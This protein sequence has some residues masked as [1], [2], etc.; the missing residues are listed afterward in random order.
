MKTKLHFLRNPRSQFGC[1]SFFKKKKKQSFRLIKFVYQ[2]GHRCANFFW[3]PLILIVIKD[4][5]VKQKKTL[6]GTGRHIHPCHKHFQPPS[7]S[8]PTS[9][10][11]VFITIVESGANKINISNRVH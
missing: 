7:L 6:L 5:T 4:R 8:L 1:A 10:M 3:T 11:H 2:F 9:F